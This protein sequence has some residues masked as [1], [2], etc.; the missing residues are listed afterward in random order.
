M[1]A[2]SDLISK[3]APIDKSTEKEHKERLEQHVA[4]LQK[5]GVVA[6]AKE[7]PAKRKPGRPPTK[8]TSKS[9][10]RTPAPKQQTD[11][12]EQ[13][14]EPSS[15]PAV[16]ALRLKSRGYITQIRAYQAHF[17]EL[18]GRELSNFN[19][20]ACSVAQLKAVIE[21]CEA[22]VADQIELESG[23]D[24]IGGGLSLLE[25]AALQVGMVAYQNGMVG[26]EIFHLKGT[27]DRAKEDPAIQKDIKLLACKYAGWM[28]RDPIWRL[29]LNIFKSAV[30][31]WTE[32]NARVIQNE[33]AANPK[34]E[35][36]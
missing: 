3:H 14:A 33:K 10:S 12:R 17:P 34:W 7:Q 9:P 29:C 15:D 11:P 8:S 35:G 23:G 4:D 27:I 22:V 32:S 31:T 21:G 25:D 13:M 30:K 24:F 2:V 36:F 5:A 28:P 18:V 19:P 16:V 6:P 1:S 20:H 26:Q